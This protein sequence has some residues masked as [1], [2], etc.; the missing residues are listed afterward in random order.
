[1]NI[2][3]ALANAILEI[4]KSES[5]EGEFFPF[6][7]TDSSEIANCV[8]RPVERTIP[9][10]QRSGYDGSASTKFLIIGSQET[11]K[12][13]EA[14]EIIYKLD[15]L[16]ART[17]FYSLD[18]LQLPSKIP[19]TIDQNSSIVVFI[20]DFGRDCRS[21][22]KRPPI[23][24][25]RGGFPRP[26]QKL[27]ILVHLFEG[28]FKDVTFIITINKEYYD[29]L[30]IEDEG[31]NLL[32]QFKKIE[33]RGL[34]S[35]QIE[36]FIGNLSTEYGISISKN[37]ISRLLKLTYGSLS[38][39]V[40]F[41]HTFHN[42]DVTEMTR[43]NVH[44]YYELFK[45]GW[46]ALHKKMNEYELAILQALATLRAYLILPH[47][48]L[49]V[50]IAKEST[51]GFSFKK[52]KRLQEAIKSLNNKF[53]FKNENFIFCYDSF[54]LEDNLLSLSQLVKILLDFSKKNREGIRIRQSL[55]NLSDRLMDENLI[56]LN[57]QVNQR[58]L[59]L[60]PNYTEIKY[61]VGTLRT[62]KKEFVEAGKLFLGM[63]TEQPDDPLTYYNYAIFLSDQRKVKT[64]EE[65]YQKALEL[66]S[67]DAD[68]HFM[69]ASVLMAQRKLKEAEEMYKK[70]IRLNPFDPAARNNYGIL[71]RKLS[72]VSDAEHQYRQAIGL[73]PDYAKAYKNL[74][75]LLSSS[76]RVQEAEKC[77]RKSIDLDSNDP[78]T[79]FNLGILF[80][81]LSKKEEAEELYRQA[82][83]LDPNYAKTY[84]NLGVLLF[85]Q[86]QYKEAEKC[87]I[88]AIEINKNYKDAHYNLTLV[89]EKTDNPEKA[90]EH[91]E[92]ITK[93]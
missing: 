34:S 63:I 19:A 51:K 60:L 24:A 85:S 20:D 10:M 48:D 57:L 55:L 58:L 18:S 67:E 42:E 21:V 64:A 54:L 76:G 70:G 71:L 37:D 1:M 13:R 41:F 14:L 91:W 79:H 17:I 6:F 16:R 78:M 29:A 33:L 53:L 52:R 66:S 3:E 28:Y 39:L 35:K 32:L 49:V 2:R 75:V 59:E 22:Q 5:S 26:L 61:N 92:A 88:K 27:E 83:E 45:S 86:A 23:L 81:R 30:K 12:T 9:Y 50:E 15:K 56:D 38:G 72:Q 82:I 62:A 87:Y 4:S 69:L 7:I 36:R 74:G 80:D 25:T 11:G 77:Y 44:R 40:Y 8:R 89:Y 31:H 46:S 47:Y 73:D 84:N 90:I 93:G 68:I 65:Y 43:E